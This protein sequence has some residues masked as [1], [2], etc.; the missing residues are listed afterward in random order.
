[1]TKKDEPVADEGVPPG[2]PRWIYNRFTQEFA[3][4]DYS[5]PMNGPFEV[6][7]QLSAL[8]GE[9]KAKDCV[10]V[11]QVGLVPYATFYAVEPTEGVSNGTEEPAS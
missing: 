8:E 4:V 7:P 2:L 10:I 5:I 3:S 6:N 9:A 1:M 11:I